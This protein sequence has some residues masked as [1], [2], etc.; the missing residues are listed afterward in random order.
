MRVEN[1]AEND[2]FERILRRLDDQHKQTD[3]V[4]LQNSFARKKT[5]GQHMQVKP[6]GAYGMFMEFLASKILPFEMH[7]TA[8]QFWRSMAQP[9]LKLRDGHYSVRSGSSFVRVFH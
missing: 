4:F 3:A 2:V 5:D 9:H 1:E 6:D 7:A 8:T